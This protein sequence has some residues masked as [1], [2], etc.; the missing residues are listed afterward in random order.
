[1]VQMKVTASVLIAAAAIAPA[2]A[3]GFETEDSLATYV[4]YTCISF[5]FTNKNSNVAAITTNSPA[6]TAEVLILT[7]SHLQIHLHE[8]R[9]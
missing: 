5:R 1:M 3:Y 7:V 8:Y 6:H 9:G 2:V 4:T